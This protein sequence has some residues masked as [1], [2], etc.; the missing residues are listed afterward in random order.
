MNF[1]KV[2]QRSNLK[3]LFLVVFYLNLFIKTF[4]LVIKSV[5]TI[6]FLVSE[7]FL[8]VKFWWS[9]HTTYH[10][11]L[12]LQALTDVRDIKF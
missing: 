8:F 6:I 11:V 1:L 10:T 7:D 2:C 4:I 12:F 3:L 5:L 9:H